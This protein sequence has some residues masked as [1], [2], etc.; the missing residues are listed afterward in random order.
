MQTDFIPSWTRRQISV[1]Y[2]CV[3]TDSNVRLSS[4]MH[5]LKNLTAVL[6]QLDSADSTAVTD[7]NRLRDELLKPENMAI[8]VAADWSK[9]SDLNVDLT[10]PWA[11]IAKRSALVKE[12]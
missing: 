11:Q 6:D 10:A 4:M 8:H 12:R 7:L 3:M 2:F 9:M 1:S 5:Q